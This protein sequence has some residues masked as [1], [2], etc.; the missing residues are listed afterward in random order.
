[1]TIPADVLKS[2]FDLAMEKYLEGYP[3][4]KALKFA[5]LTRHGFNKCLTLND[6]DAISYAQAQRIKAEFLADE[7][8]EIADTDTNFMIARNRIDARKWVASKLNSQKYGD[9]LDLHVTEHVDIRA[10]IEDARSRSREVIQVIE[11]T[12]QLTPRTTD[13]L[14]V[15]DNSPLPQSEKLRLLLE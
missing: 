12:K 10:A 3:L 4:D 7:T 15:A 8:I 13:D 5:D 1:M 11:P 6:K 2:K 14:S 9:R